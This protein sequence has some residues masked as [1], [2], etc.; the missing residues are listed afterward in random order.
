MIAPEK[1]KQKIF[2][3][4]KALKIITDNKLAWQQAE[5]TEK[6]LQ[7]PY[8]AELI[9]D[10]DCLDIIRARDWFDIR[11]LDI[12]KNYLPTETDSPIIKKF[13]SRMLRDIALIVAAHHGLIH[14]HGDSI[15]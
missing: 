15:Y 10:G 4:K 11:Y 9:H 7:K 2:G 8:I 14:A 12:Y 5:E 1:M 3:I 6:P 13:K